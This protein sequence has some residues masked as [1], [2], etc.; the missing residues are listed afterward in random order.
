[1]SFQKESV[2]EELIDWRRIAKEDKKTL[3]WCPQYGQLVAMVLREHKYFQNFYA[4]PECGEKIFAK[5]TVPDYLEEGIRRKV[6][7]EESSF[8]D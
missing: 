8:Y 7:K 5:V 6:I 3:R 2:Y 1:M 4:C